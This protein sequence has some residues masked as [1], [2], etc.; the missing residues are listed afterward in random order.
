MDKIISVIIP[1][2]NEENRIEKTLQT[3]NNLNCISQIFLID[4]GSKDLT[5]KIG[6]N[7]HGVSI[8]KNNINRGKG[9]ALK[10]GVEACIQQSDII[11]FLDADVQDSADEIIKLIGPIIENYADV[12]IAK[13]P[14]STNKSGFGLVKYLASHVLY[15]K[16]NIRLTSILS[17]QRA[18]KKKVLQG[19]YMDY[20][21]YAVE[22]GMTI[23]I[24]KGGFIIKEIEVNMFHNQTKRNLQGFIHRGRQF[25]D[26]FRYLLKYHKPFDRI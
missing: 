18:F 2:Y 7:I 13:F 19:L 14:T 4:D 15:Q 23:D 3:L 11:V 10:L 24:L 26:L 8:I 9:Y 16:T 1:A 22:L 21:G 5:S 20:P 25:F 6:L 17:G 12:T